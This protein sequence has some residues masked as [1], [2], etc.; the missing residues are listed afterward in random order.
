LKNQGIKQGDLGTQQKKL[1]TEVN[2]NEKSLSTNEDNIKDLEN[3]QAKII[4]HD[5]AEE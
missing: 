4:K 3:K 2:A 5:Q 1:T